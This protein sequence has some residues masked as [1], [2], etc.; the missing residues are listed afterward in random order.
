M[1]LAVGN[2]S[3]AHISA[4]GVEELVVLA[5][6]QTRRKQVKLSWA[7]ECGGIRHK[8]D[9]RKH[10]LAASEPHFLDIRAMVVRRLRLVRLLKLLLQLILI[11]V[12]LPRSRV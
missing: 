3:A 11:T 5:K 1:A 9:R 6:V 10:L 2:G 4:G 7:G 8:S 12:P